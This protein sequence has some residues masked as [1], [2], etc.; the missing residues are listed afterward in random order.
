MGSFSN[1]M[2]RSK[3]R[4]WAFAPIP[5]QRL[6][7]SAAPVVDDSVLYPPRASSTTQLTAQWTPRASRGTTSVR[8]RSIAQRCGWCRRLT[9]NNDSREILWEE[10]IPSA[11]VIRDASHLNIGG[12]VVVVYISIV[13]CFFSSFFFT[14]ACALGVKE[15]LNL[16]SRSTLK[17]L[18]LFDNQA[19]LISEL[20]CLFLFPVLWIHQMLFAFNLPFASTWSVWKSSKVLEHCLDSYKLDL[21]W[22]TWPFCIAICGNH[23]STLKPE[24]WDIARPVLTALSEPQTQFGFF[25]T[26]L[27]VNNSKWYLPQFG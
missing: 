26:K 17:L 9:T 7:G 14:W 10:I 8:P 27:I 13:P 18:N 20:N 12:V 19:A 6:C 25:F 3:H 2:E 23:T 4:C 22:K 5:F 16:Q 24:W 11:K 15:L 1:R 21:Q